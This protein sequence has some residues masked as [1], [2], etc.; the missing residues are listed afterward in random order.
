MASM[1]PPLQVKQVVHVISDRLC[2]QE[3]DVVNILHK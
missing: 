2:G 3:L 1:K